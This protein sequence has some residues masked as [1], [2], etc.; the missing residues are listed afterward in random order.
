MRMEQ[1]I[2]RHRMRLMAVVEGAPSIREGCRRAGIH[3]STYYAWLVRV[4]RDGPDGLVDR[5]GRTRVKSPGRIRL[6]S[7]VVALALANP[8]WGP[9]RLFFELRRRGVAVGSV[10]QVWRIL[11]AHVLNTRR[12]RYR[13]MSVARG[14]TEADVALTRPVRSRSRMGHLAAE[15]PGDLVQMD[16]FHIGSLKEARLGTAKRP[17]VVWQYTAIDV[18]SSFVWAELHTTARNPSAVHTTALAQR[19]ADDLA[20]WGWSWNQV[21]TDRGN[22]FVDHRFGDAITRL[23]VQHRFIAPGRPQSNGK[24]ERV[25]RTILEECWKPAFMSYVEPSIGGLRDDLAVYLNDYNTTRPHGGKW[26]KGRPPRE[27]IQ[28]NSGNQP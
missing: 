2:G 10:S 3:H 8:P 25:Q 5:A 21:S 15:S 6:E 12:S 20:S 14:L 1:V 24:V 19:V 4:E 16:C 28:P 22:E 26:N 17:G 11:K 27:I 9:Q 13:L 23:G 7:E 18:A